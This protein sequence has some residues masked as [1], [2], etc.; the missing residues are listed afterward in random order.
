MLLPHELQSYR[1]NYQSVLWLLSPC[2]GHLLGQSF[3]SSHR[4]RGPLQDED[5]TGSRPHSFPG[6]YLVGSE[7]PPDWLRSGPTITDS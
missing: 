4:G 7:R 3:A 1:G 2:G 6:L 5:N